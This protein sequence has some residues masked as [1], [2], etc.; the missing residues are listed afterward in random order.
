MIVTFLQF[1]SHKMTITFHFIFNKSQK[2]AEFL[3]VFIILPSHKTRYGKRFM[4][5]L[6]IYN[7]TNKMKI[8]KNSHKHCIFIFF[9]HIM[10]KSTCCKQHKEGKRD[11]N[12]GF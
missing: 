1:Q 6:R 11:F 8:N 9:F 7:A 2:Y 5:P 10:P 3:S 4:R 12:D